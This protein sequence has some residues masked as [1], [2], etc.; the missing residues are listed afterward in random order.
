ME[1]IIDNLCREMPAYGWEMVLGLG[2]GA[3]H[4]RVEEFQEAHPGLP[5]VEIDGT[6]GTRRGRLSALEEVIRRS[7]PDIVL[8][9]RIFDAYE[10]TASLK[11]R[12]GRPRLAVT[13][14]SYEPHYLY[15]ARKYRDQIDL[16]VTSGRLLAEAC[17][18]WSGI[19]RERVTSIPGGVRMPRVK[20]LPRQPEGRIL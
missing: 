20:V 3:V 9:A 1:T 5:I 13:V 6:K 2:K 14:R 15:D 10:A 19:E 11:L 8:S 17:V 12:Y 16:C 4:N 18:R 7:D